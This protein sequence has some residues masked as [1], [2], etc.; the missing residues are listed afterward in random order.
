M[1]PSNR[2]AKAGASADELSELQ[3]R[4]DALSPEAQDAQ[5]A[6]YA[7]VDDVA[8]IGVLDELR[9]EPAVLAEPEDLNEL[10]RDVLDARAAELG[11]DAPDKLPNKAAVIEAIQAAEHPGPVEDGHGAGDG[12]ST[13]GEPAGVAADGD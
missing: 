2:F 6:E 3:A 10:R 7:R 4:Y 13:P 9:A 11:V 8:L 12:V 1:L 5:D